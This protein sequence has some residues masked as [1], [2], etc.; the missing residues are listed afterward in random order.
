MNV[1]WERIC[2]SEISSTQAVSRHYLSQISNDYEHVDSLTASEEA[3]CRLS[4]RLL[5]IVELLFYKIFRQR[6]FHPLHK[7]K[8]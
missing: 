5:F 1:I 3:V 7:P 2:L 6:V 4:P 8:L